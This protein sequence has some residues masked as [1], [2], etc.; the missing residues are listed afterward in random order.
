MRVAVMR[1][2]Q[3]MAVE[4]ERLGALKRIRLFALVLSLEGLGL[5]GAAGA[6]AGRKCCS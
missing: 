5:L 6:P 1:N 3:F 2:R 4:R